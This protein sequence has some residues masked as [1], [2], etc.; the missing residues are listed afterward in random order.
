MAVLTYF[1]E[2]KYNSDEFQDEAY[3]FVPFN[4][5]FVK[6]LNR[7]INKAYRNFKKLFK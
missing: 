1:G 5:T 6:T 7:Y 3:L 2:D 4:K